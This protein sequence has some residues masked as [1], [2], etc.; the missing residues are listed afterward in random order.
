MRP[1]LFFILACFS[2]QLQAQHD[3]LLQNSKISWL[4]EYTTDYE[5]N[6]AYNTKLE[7]EANLLELQRLVN[8]NGKNGLFPDSDVNIPY[9]FSQKIY[10]GLKAGEFQCF[11]DVGLKMP[12]TQE[13]VL[14]R[15]MWKDSSSIDGFVAENEYGT[16]AFV[17]FR[18][19][20]LFYYNQTKREYGMRLLALAPIPWT[21][22]ADGYMIEHEPLL[23]IKIPQLDK[24]QR[25][26]LV[27]KANYIL[28]TRTQENSPSADQM[29]ALKGIFDIQAWATSEVSRPSHKS[30][31]VDD[32]ESLKQAELQKLIFTADT[33]TALNDAGQAVIDRIIQH[34]AL[35][36]V[37]KIRFVQNWYFDEQRL[38]FDCELTAVAPMATIVAAGGLFEF[39]KPLFYV[40]Y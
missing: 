36:D 3:D 14:A 30:L 16:E 35:D 21:S 1:I 8:N 18:V 33:I 11:E 2:S 9:Y 15:F 32:Y 4:A 10:A 13:E 37:Q 26:S 5:L 7:T 40:K 24:K 28:Q 25:K 23:W 34:N 29:T 6:P 38:W 19:R 27:K 12:L 20:Q 17:T 31:S 39:D 22:D